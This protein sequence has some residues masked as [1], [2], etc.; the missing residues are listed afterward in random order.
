VL[1]FVETQKSFFLM[2]QWELLLKELTR[3]LLSYRNALFFVNKLELD[4][5]YSRSSCSGARKKIQTLRFGG[6]KL[7]HQ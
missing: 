2:N 5:F 4:T 1:T 6:G 3:K 7:P